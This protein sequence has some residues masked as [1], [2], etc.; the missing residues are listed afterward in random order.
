VSIDRGSGGQDWNGDRVEYCFAEAASVELE[1]ACWEGK[2]FESKKVLKYEGLMLRVG[3][4]KVVRGGTG[5]GC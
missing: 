4:G 3:V 1:D 2:D 5:S